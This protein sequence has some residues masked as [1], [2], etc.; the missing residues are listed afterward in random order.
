MSRTVPQ[1]GACPRRNGNPD[2]GGNVTA[3]ER[4]RLTDFYQAALDAYAGER[5]FWAEN[6]GK[7]S[8]EDGANPYYAWFLGRNF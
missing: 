3:N 1:H 6:M 2:P 5:K 4:G 7:V 8:A